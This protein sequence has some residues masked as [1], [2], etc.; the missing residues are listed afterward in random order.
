MLRAKTLSDI[1][2]LW[3]ICRMYRLSAIPV[4]QTIQDARE[5][6][7]RAMNIELSARWN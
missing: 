6:R 2:Y 7:N 1:Y 4:F 3:R 5:Y